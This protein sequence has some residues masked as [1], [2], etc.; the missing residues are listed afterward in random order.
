MIDLEFSFEPKPW[1]TFLR[2]RQAGDVVTAGNLLAILEGEDE[3]SVE[4]A[5]REMEM[6]CIGLSVRDLPK[7]VYA[8]E[9]AL[10]LKREDLLK[11]VQATGHEP[12]F[13]DLPVE[14]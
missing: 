1:E 9:A 3:Q 10:R 8:G 11:F 5:F 6:G 13:V 2:T 12:V 4:D 14:E 7:T